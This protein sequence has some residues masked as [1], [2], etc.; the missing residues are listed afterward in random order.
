MTT[1]RRFA[2]ATFSAAIAAAGL[3][4][5]A[6]SSSAASTYVEPATG[7]SIIVVTSPTVTAAP[8]DR[9]V[10]VEVPR[11]APATVD[12]VRVFPHGTVFSVALYENGTTGYLWYNSL[13]AGSEQV[14]TFL[15]TDFVRD[16]VPPDMVG[17]GGTRYF[18]YQAEHP[19]VA[20]IQLRYQRY[21]EPAP[22]RQVTLHVVVS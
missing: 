17:V 11:D 22:I 18:R 19:G 3:V 20:T 13:P 9:G 16:P 2:S 7:P 1:K 6:A 15:D 14:V 21:W 8:P 5:V 4:A 10:V 12:L